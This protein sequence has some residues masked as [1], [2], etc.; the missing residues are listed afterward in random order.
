VLHQ[1]H[2]SRIHRKTPD[3]AAPNLPLLIARRWPAT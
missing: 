3:R 1:E 2:I